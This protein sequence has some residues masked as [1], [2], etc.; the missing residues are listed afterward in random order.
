MLNE[1]CNPA[2]DLT[3][4]AR[5]HLRP[6]PPLKSSRS[7]VDRLIHIDLVALRNKCPRLSSIRIE[8]LEGLAR[9]R[10]DPPAIDIGLI[11]F[12]LRG[13]IQHDRLR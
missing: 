4:C 6:Q 8:G 3:A 9:G 1:L 12:E 2:H 7:G 11:R 13:A 5:C 10:I